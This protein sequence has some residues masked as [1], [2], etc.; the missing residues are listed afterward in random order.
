VLVD[1]LAQFVERTP[2]GIPGDFA[3]IYGWFQIAPLEAAP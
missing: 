2:K 3:L 1:W